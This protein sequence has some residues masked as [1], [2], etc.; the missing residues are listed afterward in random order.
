MGLFFFGVLFFDG[1]KGKPQ[2]KPPFW[3]YPNKHTHTHWHELSS[4]E[5]VESPVCQPRFHSQNDSLPK[6]Y[7]FGLGPF[8]WPPPT[9]CFFPG[10]NAK[11][12]S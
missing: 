9:T 8:V 5:I 7:F 3:G 2:G 6:R 11:A 12:P 1:V 4:D 10:H